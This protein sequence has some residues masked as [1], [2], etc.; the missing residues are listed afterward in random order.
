MLGKSIDPYTN[1]QLNLILIFFFLW[2][3]IHVLNA[4]ILLALD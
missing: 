4:H 2:L 3:F 1:V